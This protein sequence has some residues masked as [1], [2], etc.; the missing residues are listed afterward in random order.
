MSFPIS[1]NN[2]YFRGQDMLHPP[3]YTLISP[4][5]H[6]FYYDGNTVAKTE[7]SSVLRD[8]KDGLAKLFEY[9]QAECKRGFAECWGS[10]DAERRWDKYDEEFVTRV[11]NSRLIACLQK[12]L[13]EIASSGLALRSGRHPGGF[14]DIFTVTPVFQLMEVPARRAFE[15]AE[16]VKEASKQRKLFIG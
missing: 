7:R 6:R 14:V 8:F 1:P 11:N 9:I 15:L 12:S 4:F 10:V 2:P 3:E 13:G 16:R 5:S